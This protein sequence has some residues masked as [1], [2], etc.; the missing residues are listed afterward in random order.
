M[1]SVGTADLIK[2]TGVTNLHPKCARE[3]SCMEEAN[4]KFRPYMEDRIL[5][6]LTLRIHV[7]RP[8][9][10]LH[11]AGLLRRF[12]RTRGQGHRR[13]LRQPSSR[14]S[15]ECFYGSVDIPEGAK[16]RVVEGRGEGT[17]GVLREGTFEI[18]K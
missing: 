18:I 1:V 11:Q 10:R 9:W 7:R 15:A 3:Y 8:I 2:E 5:P 4:S 13:V 12:R 16:G 17:G 14:G 6:R